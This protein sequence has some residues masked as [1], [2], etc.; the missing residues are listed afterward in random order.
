VV[1]GHV[2]D[3]ARTEQPF[4]VELAAAAQHL[5]E[6]VVVGR[7][8]DQAAPAAEVHRLPGGADAHA[9]VAADA[10]A[11]ARVGDVEGGEAVDVVLG[12][13]ERGVG[14]PQRREDLL[15]E[16]GVERLARDHLDDAAEHV[17]GDG[18]VPLAAGWNTSGIDAQVSQAAARSQPCGTPNSWPA[19]RYI[20]STGWAWWKP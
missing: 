18:V 13:P 15:G 4:A 1:A 9:V 10:P 14:H 3:R 7:G 20:S 5:G 16:E 19:L 11:V 12:G 17:G 6:A 8:A 2:G